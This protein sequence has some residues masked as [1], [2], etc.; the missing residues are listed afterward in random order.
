MR[1]ILLAAAAILV[2]GTS[3]GVAQTPSY[4]PQAPSTAAPAP[5]QSSAPSPSGTQGRLPPHAQPRRNEASDRATSGVRNPED[6]NMDRKI[7]SICRG[8]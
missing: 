2:M 3:F 6:I 1:T 7:N 4:Q 8:C 5:G